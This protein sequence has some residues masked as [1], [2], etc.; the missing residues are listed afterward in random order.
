M[1]LRYR[2]HHFLCTLGF[3]GKGYS[4]EFV[5]G[6]SSIAERLREAPGGD[7]E[8]ILVVEHTDSICA[9]CPNRRGEKCETEEKIQTLDRAHM[10]I[11]GLVPG[12][13]ITWGEAKRRLAS[14]MSLDTFEQACE[15]CAWKSLGVCRDALAA[16]IRK[17]QDGS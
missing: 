11:L 7:D 1:K 15:P 3:Q 4:D 5:R 10:S 8:S 2:P 17:S 9:P 12:E 6:F 13:E 16:L 14:R